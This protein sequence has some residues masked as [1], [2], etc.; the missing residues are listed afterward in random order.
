MIRLNLGKFCVDVMTWQVH[1]RLPA[2]RA[3][4]PLAELRHQALG[5]FNRAHPIKR[6]EGGLDPYLGYFISSP[7]A[8]CVN[9]RLLGITVK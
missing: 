4:L 7:S 5:S 2:D 3:R 6:F 9:C 8:L 1:D